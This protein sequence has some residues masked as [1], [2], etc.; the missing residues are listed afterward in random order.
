[1]RSPVDRD[2]ESEKR[3]AVWGIYYICRRPRLIGEADVSIRNVSC[4]EAQS[5]GVA[6]HQIDLMQDARVE[7]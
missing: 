6:R 7:S 4:I 3:G 2:L 1:M 5:C